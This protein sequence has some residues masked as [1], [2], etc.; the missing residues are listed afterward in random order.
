[1]RTLLG[2]SVA[3]A[4][5]VQGCAQLG[6]GTDT[7]G[8]GADD[9]NTASSSSSSGGPA[10]TDAS[11]RVETAP[12]FTGSTM[13]PQP[14]L[15][16][17]VLSSSSSGPV[18]SSSSASVTTGASMWPPAGDVEEPAC[19]NPPSNSSWDAPLMITMG[20]PVNARLCPTSSGVY[21][22]TTL[23]QAQYS[24]FVLQ[25]IFSSGADA[26]NYDF[27]V[28]TMI[29][30]GTINGFRCDSPAGINEDCFFTLPEAGP[31]Y[32]RAFS[33]EGTTREEFV[34]LIL[35]SAW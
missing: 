35:K 8:Q 17:G 12:G 4:L 15:E 10:S 21:F 29:D 1:M 25:V 16:P 9:G 6:N 28:G 14:I 5:V 24:D 7:Q 30:G 22:R 34:T 2:W 26:Q 32:V 19:A 33:T 20:T 11:S 23:A 18:S 3:L 27:D 13:D 31:V